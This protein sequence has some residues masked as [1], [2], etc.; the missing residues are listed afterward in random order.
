M[1]YERPSLQTIKDRIEADL[2][3][4]LTGDAPLLVNG[5]LRVLVRVFAGAM[6]ILYGFLAFI[7][8]QLFAT[9]A[10]REYLNRI[11]TMWGVARKAASFA[12]GELTFS[13]T[14]GT[15]VPTSTRVATEDGVEYETTADGTISGGSVAVA[16][17]AVE[18]GAD[19]NTESPS[20]SV[21]LVEPIA[22]VTGAVISTDFGGG[23]DEESDEDY[24]ARI[25]QRIQNPPAGGTATDFERWAKEVSGVDN[26]WTYPTTPGP[27]QVTVIFTGSATISAVETYISE[28]MPVTS[29]LTV[30]NPVDKTVDIDISITP[31]STALQAAINTNLAQI[32]DEVAKPGED[33]LISQIR[34][35][36]S[37]AGVDDYV[38]TNIE[39]DAVPVNPN[40]N[41]D[42][43]GFEYP[44][45]GTVTII[46]L[47]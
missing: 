40:A 22:G 10:E 3:S 11:G 29:D 12:T 47:T 41:L 45:L 23:E 39:V 20:P 27:G 35:A 43:N 17:S 9:T 16:A 32:F 7:A 4:R 8:D 24:R 19:A 37:S 34:D 36:I 30:D 44:L 2:E 6:H 18:A 14:N 31:N 5:I 28:R 13:G 42:F 1:P 46:E 21:D 33:V 15:L 25:L 38:I 26:A